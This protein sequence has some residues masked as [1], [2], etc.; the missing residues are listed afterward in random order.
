MSNITTKI[1][2]VEE[3]NSP[4]TEKKKWIAGLNLTHKSTILDPRGWLCSDI[5]NKSMEIISKQ[6]TNINGFQMTNLAPVFDEDSNSWKCRTEFQS[7]SLPS[8][9][10][11]HTGRDHWVMSFQNKE[12]EICIIDSLSSTKNHTIN[13][14]SRNSVIITL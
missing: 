12:N 9:Q 14:I 2:K 4:P 11:H 13:T 7:S 1:I 8:A 6:F 3:T 10:I 5:I